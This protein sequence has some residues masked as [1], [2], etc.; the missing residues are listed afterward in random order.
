MEPLVFVAFFVGERMGSFFR[1]LS[2]VLI[3]ITWTMAVPAG[4]GQQLTDALGHTHVLPE[5]IDHII[6]SGSGCLR[7][8]TYL[9]A[10]DRVVGVDDMETSK[11]RFEARPYAMANP[12][13][14]KLPVFGGF[15][16]RDNPEKIIELNPLPQVIFKTYPGSG[17]DPVKLEQKT[18]IPVVALEFGDL[19]RK[20]KDFFQA[21][22]IL[23][24]AL[25][26][27]ARAEQV[28]GFFK[29]QIRELETRTENLKDIKG[30]T[31]FV[32]GI[33]LKG[34]HGFASTEPWYP[35]FQFV[36]AKNI[37]YPGKQGPY[38]RQ[39]L[40]SKEKLLS[41]DPEILFLDLSTLQMGKGLGGLWELKTDPVYREMSAVKE[42]RVFGLLPYN[43]YTQNPGSILANAWFIGKTL[44][45]ERF[46]DIDPL[47]KADDIYQFLVSAPLYHKMDASFGNMVFK[48]VNLK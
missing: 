8:V 11:N 19:V 32:G 5:T 6:C 31:C 28:I 46:A 16:G 26:C 38:L 10:Q 47:K 40:F 14:R 29:A 27:Q 37:A 18:G 17:Y 36:H 45:P 34:P 30:R 43:W 3:L 44:Y 4:A 21:L 48:P 24:Q 13:F 39:T 25:G 35:P 15:R 2:T 9:G 41:L 23:G 22:T 1:R 20:R 42:G 12:G 7:L 33:A